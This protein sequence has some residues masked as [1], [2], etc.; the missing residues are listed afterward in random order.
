MPV[1]D[2]MN[3]TR[4]LAIVALLTAATLVIEVTFAATTTTPSAF[5]A[6]KGDHG[7]DKKQD[8]K[9]KDNG[10][11]DGNTVTTQ[12]NKQKGSQSG[13]DNSFEQSATNVI[14]THPEN[15]VMDLI[16]NQALCLNEVP[17]V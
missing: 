16:D 5:A 7:K 12:V 11:N 9:G 1:D 3:N 10:S 13:H 17:P 4:T 8:P 15:Q 2:I 6:K 14:C